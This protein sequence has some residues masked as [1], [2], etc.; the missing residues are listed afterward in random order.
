MPAMHNQ[1]FTDSRLQAPA[2]VTL[3]H[4]APYTAASLVLPMAAFEG[5]MLVSTYTAWKSALPAV[6]LSGMLATS[7]NLVVSGTSK[8]LK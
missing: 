6:V 2:L 7:L 4:V 3:A 1:V 8:T 5:R